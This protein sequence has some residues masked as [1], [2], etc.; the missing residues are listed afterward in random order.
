MNET[1][2]NLVIH[3][4]P[5]TSASWRAEL[6]LAPGTYRITSQVETRNLMPLSFGNRQGACL[7]VLGKDTQSKSITGTSKETLQCEFQ[8]SGEETVV[9]VC[10]VRAAGGQ[11]RFKKP[12]EL[13]QMAV[14]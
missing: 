8:V 3:A 5:K 9:L 10:E 2:S 6:R 11:A 1:S 4:G 7:R 13:H 12:I 14:K